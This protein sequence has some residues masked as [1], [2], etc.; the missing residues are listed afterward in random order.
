[1][2]YC[3]A[4][5]NYTEFHMVDGKKHTISKTLKDFEQALS[6]KMFLR[7]HNSYLINLSLIKKYNKGEGTVVMENDVV[8][9]VSKRRKDD[10]LSKVGLK[11]IVKSLL[12]L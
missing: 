1:V 10:F 6:K 4:Q 11:N 12:F 2:I 5:S 9:D 7:I 3:A 8:L